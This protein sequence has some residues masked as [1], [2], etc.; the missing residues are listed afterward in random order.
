MNESSREEK[1]ARFRELAQSEN[2]YTGRQFADRQQLEKLVQEIQELKRRQGMMKR[3][4]QLICDEDRESLAELGFSNKTIVKL[5]NASVA[6]QRFPVSM[7]S[8][9]SANIRRLQKRLALFQK[10]ITTGSDPLP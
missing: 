8:G 7:L 9:N 6:G 10:V 3:T 5:S 4:N 1:L 2:I